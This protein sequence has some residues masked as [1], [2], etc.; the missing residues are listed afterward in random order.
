MINV[1]RI[2]QRVLTLANKEQRGYITPQE[3]NLFADQAQMEIFEQY[4]YDINQF[5]RIPGN[6]Y[7]Y[8][9]VLGNL[10]D[11]VSL[12]IVYDRGVSLN[13]SYYAPVITELSDLYRIGTVKIRYKTGD[14]LV[15]CEE[16]EAENE[17][18]WYENS[19]L[20]KYSKKYPEIG[21]AS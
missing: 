13:P 19:P 10:K 1:D 16:L 21:R 2:Y 4:F 12:F 3:F 18:E 20:T 5:R 15:L 14:K 11:K 8:G 6:N 7:A 9:D 17:F